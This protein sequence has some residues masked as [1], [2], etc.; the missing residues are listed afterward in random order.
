MAIG[1]TAAAAGLPLVAG[2]APANTLETIENETRDM[3]GRIKLDHPR[4]ITV[5]PTAPTSPA[6]GDVWIKVT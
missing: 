3:I 2:T 4:K 5:S 6:E 1:D